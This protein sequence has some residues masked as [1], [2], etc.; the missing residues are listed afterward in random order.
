MSIK[1]VR[2]I[3]VIAVRGERDG[4]AGYVSAWPIF[5]RQ[6]W[7]N[8]AWDDGTITT[9]HPGEI[10]APDEGRQLARLNAVGVRLYL[11]DRMSKR[12]LLAIVMEHARERG[13]SWAIGGPALWSRDELVNSILEFEF[14]SE[15]SAGAPCP[16]GCGCRLGTDD[17]DRREC[18]C[19]GGCCETGPQS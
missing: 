1:D 9:A 19:D 2:G 12:D 6:D 11:L 14:R 8:V 18:G 13:A 7:V 16:G 5:D 17:A 15:A 3:K 4:Q 10:I